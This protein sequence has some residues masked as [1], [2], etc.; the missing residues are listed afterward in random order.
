MRIGYVE[1]EVH[2]G[3]R[4]MQEVGRYDVWAFS[5]DI[6]RKKRELLYS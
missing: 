2:T 4:L 1:W 5:D 6:C 3:K